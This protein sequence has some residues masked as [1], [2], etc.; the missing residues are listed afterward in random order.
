MLWKSRES[1]KHLSN[2]QGA[3]GRKRLRPLYLI[4]CSLIICRQGIHVACN[5]ILVFFTMVQ[6]HYQTSGNFAMP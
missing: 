2:R 4:A 1:R 6:I 3:D 5:I